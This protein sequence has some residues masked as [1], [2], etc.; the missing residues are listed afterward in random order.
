[1]ATTNLAVLTRSHRA[2]HAKQ[3]AKRDQVKEVVFDD[4]ARRYAHRHRALLPLTLLSREFLTGFHKRKLAKAEAARAKAK[5]RE[6]QER[7]ETRREVA[8][9][10]L[11]AC[12]P[13]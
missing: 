8:M 9:I 2:I 11:S 3:R 4:T 5:E 12:S 10:H 1:M 7:L 6:K 13:H